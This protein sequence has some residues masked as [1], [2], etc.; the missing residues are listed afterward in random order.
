MQPHISVKQ[1]RFAYKHNV[2]YCTS[3]FGS[4]STKFQ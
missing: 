1:D 4:S 3:I 2:D